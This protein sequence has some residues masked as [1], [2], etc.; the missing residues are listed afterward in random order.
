MKLLHLVLFLL[1]GAVVAPAASTSHATFTTKPITVTGGRYVLDFQ[2]FW[3]SDDFPG[4]SAP[5][6]VELVDAGGNLTGAA[7]GSIYL[8]G[9]P[10]AWGG[11]GTV[12]VLEGLAHRHGTGGAVADGTLNARWDITGLGDGA[13]TLR[14]FSYTTEELGQAASTVWTTTLDAGGGSPPTNN[15]PNIAWVSAPA[16]ADHGQGYYIAARGH[17]ADG[18]LAQVQVWKHGQPF[19]YAGGGDGTQSDAGNWTS[20]AGPQTV[21][22]TAQAFDADGAASAIISHTVAIGAPP[23]VF[24]QLTTLAGPGGSVSPGG[25]FAAGTTTL[26]TASPEPASEFA[27]WSGGAAGTANPAGVLMDGPRTV[28]ANFVLRQFALITGVSGIGS[29]TPGGTYPYGTLVTLAATA[30]ATSRF[31]GWAGDSTGSEPVTLVLMTGPRSIQ[32]LFE[33]KTAQTI[34]FPHP[35]D[36]PSG[37]LPFL[38][39][40]TTSSGLPVN[41]AVLDGPAVLLGNQL[42]IT[43]PGLVTVQASQPGDGYYLPAPPVVR[44]FNAIAPV[45]LRYSGAGRTLLHEQAGGSPT[46]LV[47]ETP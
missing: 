24:F 3:F 22:F 21:T 1:L 34:S 15:A 27:G 35:G 47:L 23:P 20:D 31:A 44:S 11:P 7:G 2:V 5:G 30:N 29:V 41:F 19:A 32:A 33:P 45:S 4:N 36:R 10:Q 9:G 42:Q 8:D 39:E 37:S 38:L 13:Y 46:H 16:G 12:T 40:A 25:Q 43:G 18:N 17:D 26:V 6:R 28:Q 14:F